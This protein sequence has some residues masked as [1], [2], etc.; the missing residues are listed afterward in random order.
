MSSPN[1]ITSEYKDVISWIN[2]GIK[3][4]PVGTSKLIS[5]YIDFISFAFDKPYKVIYD[6]AYLTEFDSLNEEEIKILEIY[7][8]LLQKRLQKHHHSY[9]E[10]RHGVTNTGGMA[11]HEPSLQFL[12]LIPFDF[13]I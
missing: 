11:Q 5:S 7:Y 2:N 10:Y 4:D 3:S 12:S 1:E 6:L 13:N 8:A 9:K